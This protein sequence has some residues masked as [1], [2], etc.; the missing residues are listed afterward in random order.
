M[1]GK[2]AD[3]STVA[4][5]G[6]VAKLCCKSSGIFSCPTVRLANRGDG[7]SASRRSALWEDHAPLVQRD[8]RISTKEWHETGDSRPG[9]CFWSRGVRNKYLSLDCIICNTAE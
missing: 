2:W 5:V 3:R 1:K 4:G 7:L 9:T 6:R 8:W